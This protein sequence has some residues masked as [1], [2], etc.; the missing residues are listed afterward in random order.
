MERTECCIAT[1]FWE[2]MLNAMMMKSFLMFDFKND[3]DLIGIHLSLDILSRQWR[4][5]KDFDCNLGKIDTYG[6]LE[7][8]NVLNVQHSNDWGWTK[9]NK[10]LWR[11]I[12]VWWTHIWNYLWKREFLYMEHWIS[13]LDFIYVAYELQ[14]THFRILDELGDMFFFVGSW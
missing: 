10:S 6:K 12:L 1:N 8:M 5:N 13:G 7:L 14:V 4:C 9:H 2:L 3:H 11:R